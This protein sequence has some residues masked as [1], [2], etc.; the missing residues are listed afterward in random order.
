MNPLIWFR[1][2]FL[3]VRDYQRSMR[4]VQSDLKTLQRMH[5]DL[6]GFIRERT[7]VNVDVGVRDPS[8]IIII[9]RYKG[10]DYVQSYQLDT[11]TLPDLVDHLKQLE[12]HAHLNRLD[13][14]RSFH[15]FITRSL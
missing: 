12:R 4:A 9:G 3:I 11:D 13:A 1:T 15:H 14:P 7:E 10:G 8:T 5:L 6:D 2:L